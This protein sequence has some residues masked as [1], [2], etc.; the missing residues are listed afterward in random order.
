ML[1]VCVLLIFVFF[2]GVAMT[3]GE[4][5]WSNTVN[6]LCLLISIPSAFVMGMPLGMWGFEQADTDDQYLWYFI[7]AGQWIVFFAVMLILKELARRA[8][9]V[10]V[11]FIPQLEMI[12]GPLMGLAVA[13]VFT[14]FLTVTIVFGPQ[15]AGV[16]NP[17]KM[18]DWEKSLLENSIRPAYQIVK[19]TTND[20]AEF[21]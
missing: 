10:R 11:R 14:S 2:A 4:G 12:A 18:A 20:A 9:R 15:A 17:T 19:A 16:W 5:L 21:N 13:V 7:F 1:Y 3:V 8:S 6:L